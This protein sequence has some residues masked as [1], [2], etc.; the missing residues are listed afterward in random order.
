MLKYFFSILLIPFLAC[1]GLAP[2][3]QE[4]I[5]AIN[6]PSVADIKIDDGDIFQILVS[7]DSL[8]VKY[9][10]TYE[11]LENIDALDKLVKDKQINEFGVKVAV[12][13]NRE[14]PFESIQPIIDLLRENGIYKFNLVTDMSR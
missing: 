1:N 10:N 14:L 5:Q 8:V 13:P 6:P 4:P 12:K 3:P 7:A 11:Y 9:N 2:K